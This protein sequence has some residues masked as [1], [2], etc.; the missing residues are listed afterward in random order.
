[1]TSPIRQLRL[2]LAATHIDVSELLRVGGVPSL[3]HSEIALLLP[4]DCRAG[5]R[6]I[7]LQL[8]NRSF[9]GSQSEF[10]VNS[11]QELGFD[12]REGRCLCL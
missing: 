1:M 6:E 8:P 12:S 3:N 9:I 10:Q 4:A 11:D 7:E 5:R 2:C